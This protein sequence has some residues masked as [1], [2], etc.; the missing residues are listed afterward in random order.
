MSVVSNKINI[1]R[2]APRNGEGFYDTLKN[3]IDTFFQENKIA[4]HGNNAMKWK[5][6]AMVA[7]FFVPYIF[8]VTGLGA[9][10][11]FLFFGLWFFM[12]LGMVGIGCGVHHDSNH[13]SYSDNKLVNKIVGDVV[14][15]VGGYDV[16]W[17][18]QHNV[19][20]HTYTNIAGLDEDIDAGLLLRFSPQTKRYKVHRF[21]HIYA[22]FLYCLL[23]LQW[24]T[25]KDYRLIFLYEKKGLLKKEKLTLGKALLELS[26][27]KVIYF[28]YILVLPILFSG[29]PWYY[30]VYGFLILHAVAG[31]SLSCIFQLAH[32]LEDAE[33][34]LPPESRKMENN[35]AIHQLLN[36]ANFAPRSRIMAWFIG[37]LNHQIEHHLFPHICHVH[38][39]KLAVIV[40]ETAQ[41]YG[42]PY[43]EQPTFVHALIEHGKMLRKMG[44]D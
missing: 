22:W 43:L 41:N 37:G 35:W 31:L 14:N 38:Y 12:G 18:I 13:G 8:I 7:L 9:A 25:Y 40:R 21:Q 26:I 36:T 32:V 24:V 5:T 30:V 15:V 2:F 29:M 19:L 27:Y 34:P 28:T 20:H 16:T 44:R 3:K 10:S 33:F 1:V 23:T 4:P 17:R 6:V 11:P 42:L 39:K